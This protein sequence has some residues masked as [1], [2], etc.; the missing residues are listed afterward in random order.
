MEQ[1]SGFI[2]LEKNTDG[3]AFDSLLTEPGRKE[4]DGRPFVLTE[5][6][7]TKKRTTYLLRAKLAGGNRN[8][9]KVYGYFD[10]ILHRPIPENAII[11]N[12]KLVRK[13][14]G[15]KFK[16]TVSFTLTLPDPE[17]KLFESDVIGVDLNL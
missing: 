14:T 8:E 16:H 2:V 15:D 9:S 12:A 1:A 7:S 17:P 11:Q 6:S 13:R 3:V 5:K 10:L 4:M